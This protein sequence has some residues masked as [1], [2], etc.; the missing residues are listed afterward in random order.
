MFISV[1]MNS[2][3]PTVFCGLKSI[4]VIVLNL[5]AVPSVASRTHFIL[6]SSVS[7]DILAQEDFPNLSYTFP[8]LALE[9]AISKEAW[10]F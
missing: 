7:L 6:A 4:S 8:A 5:Q 9:S 2:W 3:I 10:F 1:S